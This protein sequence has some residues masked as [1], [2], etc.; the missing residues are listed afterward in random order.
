MNV[1]KKKEELKKAQLQTIKKTALKQ[2][3]G[4]NVIIDDAPDL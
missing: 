1:F 3:Q 4:G 2:V